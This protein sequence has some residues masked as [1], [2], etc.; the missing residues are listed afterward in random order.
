MEQDGKID[1][2]YHLVS[3][4]CTRY[5]WTITSNSCDDLLSQQIQCLRKYL[6]NCTDNADIHTLRTHMHSIAICCLDYDQNR[7]TN[8]VIIAFIRRSAIK[9]LTIWLDKL[10]TSA[11][12]NACVRVIV[13]LYDMTMFNICQC[14]DWAIEF[15]FILLIYFTYKPRLLCNVE[16]LTQWPAVRM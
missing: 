3:G 7:Q 11:R 1:V 5:I 10:C 8:V 14:V 4:W 2:M 16:P 9:W 15:R 6:V 13:W 12:A